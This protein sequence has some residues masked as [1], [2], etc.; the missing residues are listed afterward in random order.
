MKKNKKKIKDKKKHK[1]NQKQDHKNKNIISNTP[2]AA[3]HKTGIK[4]A[5]NR[6]F[7]I[8]ET[9]RP[10]KTVSK[11]QNYT[12]SEPKSAKNA[13]TANFPENSARPSAAI[14][15]ADEILL[16][17]ALKRKTPSAQESKCP[18]YFDYSSIP[19]LTAGAALMFPDKLKLYPG[20][21]LKSWFSNFYALI[22]RE[23]NI[24]AGNLKVIMAKG[25]R[26]IPDGIYD[27][28]A[29]MDYSPSGDILID[30]KVY[31]FDYHNSE[32]LVNS[33]GIVPVGVLSTLAPRVKAVCHYFRFALRLL[34]H[35][36]FY[37][38]I[39]STRNE[40]GYFYTVRW[41]ASTYANEVEKITKA[42]NE[43]IPDGLV[44]FNGAVLCSAEQLKCFVS[45]FISTFI[46]DA[47]GRN[48]LP[49][50]N[51][52]VK[53]MLSPPSSAA[54]ACVPPEA[55][56]EF[57][58]KDDNSG[59]ALKIRPAF[60]ISEGVENFGIKLLADILDEDSRKLLKPDEL[61]AS[62]ARNFRSICAPLFAGAPMLTRFI[63]EDSTGPIT[64]TPA[65]YF[66][67]CRG[68]LTKLKKF[69]VHIEMPEMAEPEEPTIHLALIEKKY[70]NKTKK[71]SLLTLPTPLTSL[72]SPSLS[73][74]SSS[75]S[76]TTTTAAAEEAL[77]SNKSQP[78]TADGG[79][80]YLSLGELVKFD[81]RIVLGDSDI[82]VAEFEKL[83]Q[84]YGGIIKYNGKYFKCDI[85]EIN[86]RLKTSGVK[87]SGDFKKIMRASLTGEFE[88]VPLKLAGGAAKIIE[89][90]TS[91]GGPVKLP[92]GL[93]ARL[94]PYQKR[95]YEWLYKNARLS[96][97]SLLADDMGLG[98]TV[99]TIA[100][101]LKLKE[102]G[103]IGKNKA[104]VIVPTTLATN[105][106]K[107]IEK[108]A[109]SLKYDIY[110]GQAR[111]LKR[112]NIDLLIT[113]YGILRNDIN[114]FLDIKWSLAIADEAQNIKNPA[115]V[116]TQALKKIDAGIKIAMTGTPIENRLLDIWSIFD[117]LNTGYLGGRGPFI[118][119]IA[120]PVEK[121]GCAATVE[122]FKKMTRP[123]ILRRLKTDKNIITDL[124]E[125]IEIDEFCSMTPRQAILYQ[126]L[127]DAAMTPIKTADGQFARK[128]LILKL[129]LELKQVCNHPA[130]YDKSTATAAP[131]E[132]GKM[133]TCMEILAEIINAGEKCL[134]FTQFVATGKMLETAANKIEGA[135]AI[136]LHGQCGRNERAAMIE[137]FQKDPAVNVFILSLRAGGTGIN[138][139]AAG[140]IIHYDLWW[141]PAVEDQATGRAHRIGQINKVIV[142]R[143]ITAG[144]LEEKIGLMLASKKKLAEG[145]L[146][147]GESWLA[148][149]SDD[150]L[151]E[152]VKL[153]I[154]KN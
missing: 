117:F 38:Q 5:I 99:Q 150:E 141:N 79:A 134:I 77:S 97:G 65:E 91:D 2:D 105:W 131:E 93:T 35:G 139:T 58:L 32:A 152:L 66:K 140:K 54:C 114:D 67:F 3:G 120:R 82:S 96:M 83:S 15:L 75:A 85:D 31:G 113:T 78:Q 73:S 153:E 16:A 126:Q 101:M 103:V 50:D 72:S 95:G 149:L 41:L 116:Q 69:G 104:L 142:Y 12:T 43:S 128:G 18:N 111:E 154:G 118:N 71:Q 70:T 137:K 84:K 53:I 6:F 68:E 122:K 57:N 14:P 24:Y 124:P 39:I 136:F 89:R 29:G 151:S 129:L 59:A 19:D 21:D 109:P 7:N 47:L 37:P 17:S 112:K 81:W 63:T 48:H 52:V 80:S 76:A 133:M 100:L 11:Q 125:K 45:F 42:M 115:A 56:V 110:H 145:A 127:I 25:Y 46:R 138:L 1:Q 64:L 61:D 87:P 10:E 86:K 55:I 88:G 28:N 62:T 107:E 74:P 121:N 132:S 130:Q 94:R 23:A 34:I 146:E 4:E 8:M 147:A 22:R 51:P 27:I 143:M 90:L 92:A 49:A 119:H 148:N 33:V 144:T 106:A 30:G 13:F 60:I 26:A 36:A 40:K 135:S 108:F 123:F 20:F 9:R 102:E 44:E 98:K